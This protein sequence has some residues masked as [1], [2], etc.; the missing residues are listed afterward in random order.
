[1]TPHFTNK[2][3]NLYGDVGSASI[4]YRTLRN[5][6]ERLSEESLSS[7]LDAVRSETVRSRPDGNEI[8]KAIQARLRQGPDGEE[9][10]RPSGW[11]L[12]IDETDPI[13][14]RA[15][16][17][18]FQDRMSGVIL[19]GPPGTSKSWYAM[20]IA[21]HLTDNDV[22]RI[23]KIQFHKS[24]QYENFV[25]SYVPGEGGE[26]FELREQLLLLV[27]RSAEEQPDDRFVILIDELSRSDPGRV[28]GEALTYMEPTRRGESF[29][30]AS[31]K[32]SRIPRNICFVATMN[33]RDK[34]VSEIDDAFDRRMGK[35]ALD[36]SREI[37]RQ[38]LS[39]NE[40]APALAGKVE[41]FFEWVNERYYPLG[42]TFFLS[43]RDEVGLRR[44]WE[45]QLRFAFEKEFRFQPETL[46]AI[47]AKYFEVIFGVTAGPSDPA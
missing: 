7:L 24:Y 21:L 45:N 35:I 44:V 46:M 38:F 25:E 16:E 20:Q 37:L 30:L 47:R 19:V 3:V 26:G 6:P 43:V 13:L 15:L 18:L 31:G 27:A 5:G 17:L 36:P 23:R 39:K 1:M 29:I 4:H 14:R 32:E 42:H 10:R 11:E 28:F 9:R 33:S 8:V 12:V 40:M 41:A 22:S 34:S 2:T